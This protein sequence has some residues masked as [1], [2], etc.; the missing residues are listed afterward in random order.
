MPHPRR[1][2]RP[3][4]LVLQGQRLSGRQVMHHQAEAEIAA[5]PGE[6]HALPQ[7]RYACLKCRPISRA[8]GQNAALVAGPCRRKR[9]TT[10]AVGMSSRGGAADLGGPRRGRSACRK[11]RCAVS[12]RPR[13]TRRTSLVPPV[14]RIAHPAAGAPCRCTPPPRLSASQGRQ[15]QQL[16]RQS[17]WAESGRDGRAA[18]VEDQVDHVGFSSSVGSDIRWVVPG[19]RAAGAAA[20]STMRFA[21]VRR[22]PDRR[23]K[24]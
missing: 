13:G 17:S 8:L 10:T 21:P 12:T 20:H 22:S 15:A 14:D 23:R 2:S 4:P 16:R 24:S 5:P 9:N 3:S 18:Q 1:R 11:A 19:D 7:M 6:H